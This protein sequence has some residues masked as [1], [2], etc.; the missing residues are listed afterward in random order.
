MK[1]LTLVNPKRNIVKE[2]DDL[3]IAIK[4]INKAKVKLALVI[5]SEDK[6]TG[7]LTDGDIRRGL[8][9]NYT[10]SLQCKDVMNKRPKYSKTENKDSLIKLM[11]KYN[12][13]IPR[14]DKDKKI[15]NL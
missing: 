7:V 14:V 11:Q 6:L 12:L 5:N 4:V 10:L 2:S 3:L 9:N 8:L 15:R 1:E 13:P